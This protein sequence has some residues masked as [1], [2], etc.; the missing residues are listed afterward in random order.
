VLL[1][2]KNSAKGIPFPGE[3]F[4]NGVNLR[5]FVSKYTGTIYATPNSVPG[6]SILAQEIMMAT[7][8]EQ[9]R[10]IVDKAT[11]AAYELKNEKLKDLATEYVKVMH[12][13]IDKGTS[14]VSAELTRLSTL[15]GSSEV[16]EKKK[17]NLLLRKDVLFHFDFDFSGQE[18]VPTLSSNKPDGEL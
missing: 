1:F 10:A 3:L 2:L 5:R 7:S 17:E 8:E 18:S 11:S 9:M 4:P 16:N 13:I 12:K 6:F 15:L 14:F